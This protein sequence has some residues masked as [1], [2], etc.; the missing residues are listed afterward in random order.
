MPR[1]CGDRRQEFAH[2]SPIFTTPI[3]NIE[4]CRLNSVYWSRHFRCK[5]S[6]C[7]LE[8]S[9]AT[10]WLYD[11][12]FKSQSHIETAKNCSVFFLS[13]ALLALLCVFYV[14]V[15]FLRASVKTINLLYA[16][17]ALPFCVVKRLASR[18]ENNKKQIRR[19]I[20][21]NIL[22]ENL[23]FCSVYWDIEA[24]YIYLPALHYARLIFALKFDDSRAHLTQCLLVK[25]L[26]TRLSVTFQ[27]QKNHFIPP[28]KL[29]KHPTR[30]RSAQEMNE[31]TVLRR[32]F[33]VAEPLKEI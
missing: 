24:G 32:W 10:L 25:P 28:E 31:K 26:M 22:D 33:V 1:D 9:L 13:T 30:E 16:N 21:R 14:F 17:N 18:C 2:F 27:Q 19:K 15:R 11:P 23:N 4:I 5:S 29:H 12:E 20:R 3:T 6:R 8:V 7:T